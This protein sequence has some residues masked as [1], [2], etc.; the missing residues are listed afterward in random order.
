MAS[1]A[2]LAGLL[3]MSTLFNV[4]GSWILVQLGVPA[5]G[6]VRGGLAKEGACKSVLLTESSC[7][8]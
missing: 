6:F 3:F 1:R 7:L 2:A 4:V 8:V 5:S